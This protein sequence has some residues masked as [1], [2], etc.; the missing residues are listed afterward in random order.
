[1]A[2]P[3][4]GALSFNDAVTYKEQVTEDILRTSRCYAPLFKNHMRR[5]GKIGS[6]SE[7][8]EQALSQGYVTLAAPYTTGSPTITVSAPS[9]FNPFQTYLKPGISQLQTEAGTL[10]FNLTA[11]NSATSP[12]V[13]TL[14]VSSGTDVNLAT[15]TKLYIMRNT[16]VGENYGQQNDTAVSTSNYNFFTNFSYTLKIANPVAR[17][18]FLHFGQNELSFAQQLQNLTPDAI[19]TIERGIGKGQRIQGANPVTASGF[20]RTS[21]TGSQAGGI[22]SYVQNTG[23][24]TPTTAAAFSEDLLEEDFINL[25]ERGAFSK[26]G[27]MERDMGFSTCDI[28]LSEA[29]F[30]NAQKNVRLERPAEKTLEGKRWG[31]WVTEYAVNGVVGV[32]HISDALADD[33][34][35]YVP[36]RDQIKVDVFRF[37]DNEGETV[38]GDN[39]TMIVE[40]TFTT[41]VRAPWTLGYRT[42][43]Q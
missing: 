43:L 33:E 27:E 28:Y 14:N 9:I 30:A 40:N 10:I 20:T 25:R 3:V 23:G 34:I 16:E 29:Q 39:T 6:K 17:G 7:W 26:M 19:R 4:V 11:T 2:T 32:F 5:V 37:L 15:G 8:F 31:T 38:F 22:V 21:G 24:Y 42:N 41:Q 1:M 12:T 36:N 35:I 18:Q 13:L